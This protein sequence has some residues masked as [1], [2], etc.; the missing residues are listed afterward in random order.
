MRLELKLLRVSAI[1]IALAAPAQ[2][3]E[4]A[5]P[6]QPPEPIP[7]N[8][9]KWIPPGAE[10]AKEI[11]AKAAVTSAPRVRIGLRLTPFKKV[12]SRDQKG[13]A[14]PRYVPIEP[15]RHTLRARL[16]K[17]NHF[18]IGDWHVETKPLKWIRKSR[19]Y[20]VRISIYRR[21]GAFGQLEEF[22]GSV[23]LA[24]VLDEQDDNTHVLLGVVRRRLRDK[25]NNPLVDI[26]AGFAPAPAG[27]PG[28]VA[29]RSAPKPEAPKDF[30]GEL[31]RGRF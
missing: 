24:G 3:Q 22:A 14:T 28:P 27:G 12:V 11:N 6:T 15:L 17:L 30:D 13:V 2:A 20:E 26:V 16:N 19:R 31:L 25:M 7:E 8:S 23:D 18:F 1:L 9:A 5:F 29:T 10:A 21:Y 4:E